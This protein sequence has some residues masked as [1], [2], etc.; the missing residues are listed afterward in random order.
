MVIDA[1][2]G[3][4]SSVI[5]I[6][7][8][9]RTWFGIRKKYKIE[10]KRFN[11][12]SIENSDPMVQGAIDKIK[13]ELIS[14]NDDLFELTQDEID[15]CKRKYKEQLP[16]GFSYLQKKEIDR[17]VEEILSKVNKYIKSKMTIGERLIY[18]EV[19]DTHKKI[20]KL[21]ISVENTSVNTKPTK[22]INDMFIV[23]TTNQLPVQFGYRDKEIEDLLKLCKR[24]SNICIQGIGGIGKTTILRYLY[25]NMKFEN[26]MP[27]WVEYSGNLEFDILSS[28]HIT[29]NLSVQEQKEKL[30]EFLYLNKGNIII[31]IDDIDERFKR[32]LY[33]DVIDGSARIIVT[34]RLDSIT[35]SFYIYEVKELE[36]DFAINLFWEYY[37]SKSDSSIEVVREMV[38]NV[39]YHTLM[40]EL[41][42]K[43]AAFCDDGL[44]GFAQKLSKNG[45]KDIRERLETSH[46]KNIE[47]TFAEHITMLFSIV[48]MTEREKKILKNFAISPN[49]QLPVEYKKWIIDEKENYDVEYQNLLHKGWISKIGNGYEMHPIM[50]E[51]ILLQEKPCIND[52][53]CLLQVMNSEEW[54]APDKN[55]DD[56]VSRVNIVEAFIKYFP[57]ENNKDVQI[58]ISTVA[59]SLTEYCM[60][61]RAKKYL[62]MNIEN[63]KNEYG[64]QSIIVARD[65]YYMSKIFNEAYQLSEAEIYC[66]KSLD[67]IKNIDEEKNSQLEFDVLFL[68]GAIY[69]KQKKYKKAIEMYKEVL[70]VNG[71][72]MEE[73]DKIGVLA[74]CFAIMIDESEYEQAY[75]ILMKREADI[76]MYLQ[77]DSWE[78]ATFYQNCANLYFNGFNDFEKAL[79][80]DEMALNIRKV[81]LEIHIDTAQSYFSVA[82]DL[83]RINKEKNVETC[84]NYAQKSYDIYKQL[85]GEDNIITKNSKVLL[86]ML[87]KVE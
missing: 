77:Q 51:A 19:C 63:D 10:N 49:E 32:D 39:K 53:K 31:F 15:L 36:E 70:G 33:L 78:L 34:S 46:N 14:L 52:V 40:I 26:L 61:D 71:Y 48:G 11:F 22:K 3:L 13:S 7:E 81:K 21:T 28:L 24:Y 17:L 64:P 83:Y 25:H 4:I 47:S 67:I 85:L 38:K 41:M 69:A 79:K 57:P 37:G 75:Q 43:A 76:V 66:K 65:Y 82:Y 74:N 56:F 20:D 50:K 80:Y 9:G 87:T 6:E 18:R 44:K 86:D 73:T 8:A 54:L 12:D 58:L 60:F 29:E 2:I 1:L 45:Y 55:L 5:T 62:F 68:F 42:A 35:D 27:I 59:N 16:M 72:Q 23:K 84:K 30:R